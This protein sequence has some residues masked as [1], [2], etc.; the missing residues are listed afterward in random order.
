MRIYFENGKLKDD[1]PINGFVSTVDA[2]YGYSA[3]KKKLDILK[4]ST[5]KCSVYTNSLVS[6]SNTYCWNDSL[7]APELYVRAGKDRKFIRVDHLTT[8]ELRVGHNLMKLY[9]AKEFNKLN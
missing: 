5:P 3:N 8:R 7:K 9:I 2:Q 1:V 4:Q 6:L